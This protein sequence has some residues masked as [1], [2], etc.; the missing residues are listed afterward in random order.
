MSSTTPL[1][2]ARIEIL[3]NYCQIDKLWSDWQDIDKEARIIDMGGY[4][5]QL[6]ANGSTEGL[7]ITTLDYGL[8]L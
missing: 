6:P 2:E 4:T 1:R 8:C 3:I 5:T 7:E